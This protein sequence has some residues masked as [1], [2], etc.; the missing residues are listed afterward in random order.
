MKRLV[1]NGFVASFLPDVEKESL[2]KE[3]D[4]IYNAR[5]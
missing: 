3:V 4:D 5:V 1:S 2:L